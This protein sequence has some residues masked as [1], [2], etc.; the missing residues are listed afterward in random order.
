MRFDFNH[1][2][3]RSESM[4]VIATQNSIGIPQ[5]CELKTYLILETSHTYLI[6]QTKAFSRSILVSEY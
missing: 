4:I 5:L 3:L 1:L 2:K 6:L